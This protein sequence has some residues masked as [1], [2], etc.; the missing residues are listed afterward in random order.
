MATTSD[1]ALLA[2]MVRELE[3]QLR[4]NLPTIFKPWVA[5][6]DHVLHYFKGYE[7]YVR[8]A[9]AFPELPQRDLFLERQRNPLFVHRDNT[10]SL[11]G[12]IGELASALEA[13]LQDIAMELDAGRTEIGSLREQVKKL[14]EENADLRKRLASPRTLG[15][16]TK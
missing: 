15:E 6:Q 3:T 14:A 8:K 1:R 2:R 16:G 4:S 5:H 12:R 11:L 13:S 9:L 7:D 10:G